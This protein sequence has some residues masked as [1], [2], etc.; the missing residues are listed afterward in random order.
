VTDSQRIPPVRTARDD[1]FRVIR[2]T[3]A[4]RGTVRMALVPAALFGWAVLVGGFILSGAGR[5]TV[6]P[7]SGTFDIAATVSLLVLMAGF[8]AVHALH[9][10]VERI[11]RY[12]QVFYEGEPGGPRWETTAMRVGPGLPGSGVDPLFTLLFVA[13]TLVNL[14]TVF[15]GTPTRVEA[16][17]LIGLHVAFAVRIVRARLAAGRQRARD[18]EI[19]ERL[20]AA[21]QQPPKPPTV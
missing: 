16:A 11:G 14:L 15:T 3:I 8:E 19:F 18:L 17:I 21:D 12:L 6:P 10:G 2:E 4:T 5:A 20:R 13:A 1:E 9:V 7:E